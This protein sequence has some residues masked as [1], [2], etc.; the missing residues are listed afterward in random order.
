MCLQN[1]NCAYNNVSTIR[2]K[3]LYSLNR[4]KVNI[5]PILFFL[6]LAFDKDGRL[7]LFDH[8]RQHP[9]LYMFTQEGKLLECNG[10]KPLMNMSSKSGSKCRFLECV[11]ESVF[12]VDLGTVQFY[13]REF[14]ISFIHSL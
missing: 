7:I 2:I 4:S 12:V 10:F 14:L 11:D 1:T 5:D 13:L 8:G 9:K 3:L 6:G